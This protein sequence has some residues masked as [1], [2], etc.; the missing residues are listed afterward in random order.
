MDR[1]ESLIKV[2][3]GRPGEAELAAV[4]AVLLA[5]RTGAEETPA[6]ETRWWRRPDVYT[7]PSSWLGGT[8]S[9]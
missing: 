4:V 3:R 1:E 5:L 2:E 9:S 7:A 8:G 6:A